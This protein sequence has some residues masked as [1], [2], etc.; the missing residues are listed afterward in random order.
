[1]RTG[2]HVKMDRR[3]PGDNGE[4]YFKFKGNMT[5]TMF[6][7]KYTLVVESKKDGS[8]RLEMG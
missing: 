7:K 8:V 4:L 1:M 3:S 6:L 5:I 2:D